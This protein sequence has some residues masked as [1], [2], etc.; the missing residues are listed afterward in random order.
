MIADWLKAGVVEAGVGFTPTTKGVPQGA[1]CS[2][3]HK[4]PYEQCWVMRSVGL[5][6]LVGRVWGPER[7]A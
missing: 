7:C 1:L 2:A 4:P 3:E 6:G 5:F